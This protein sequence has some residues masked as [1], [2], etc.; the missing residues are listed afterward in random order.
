MSKID[1]VYKMGDGCL[2]GS[3]LT[4]MHPEMV[5]QVSCA[6]QWCDSCPGSASHFI[7]L[8]LELEEANVTPTKADHSQ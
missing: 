4:K 7:E 1:K 5:V 3:P 6:T 8:I 2:L